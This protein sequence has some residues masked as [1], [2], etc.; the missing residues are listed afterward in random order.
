M[1]DRVVRIRHDTAL[2]PAHM[3]KFRHLSSLLFAAGLLGCGHPATRQE[4]TLIFDRSAELELAAQK[5]V[6]PGL[7]R[8]RV[9][10]LRA[11]RGEE[12]IGKCVGKRITADALDCVQ[13]A[14]SSD[15]LEK[16]LY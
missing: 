5:I 16:C 2:T 12:L 6:D 4:C 3:T 8:E 1:L 13:N 7:V 11:A 9:E 14:A 15:D 10:S